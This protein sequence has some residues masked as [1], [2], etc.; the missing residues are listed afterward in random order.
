MLSLK[1]G[2][3]F[4]IFQCLLFTPQ[5]DGDSVWHNG[6]RELD[7]ILIVCRREEQHL[8]VLLQ[9]SAT[10]HEDT[11]T[12]EVRCGWL[13][14]LMLSKLSSSRLS[15]ITT[16]LL[17]MACANFITGASYVAEN[18]SIWQ[19][20]LS[21]LLSGIAC[22]IVCNNTDFCAIARLGRKTR[23]GVETNK[24]LSRRA[25]TLVRSHLCIRMDWSW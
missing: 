1:Q 15:R 9:A 12:R 24:E 7:D 6:L 25:R 21:K 2:N 20:F 3:L 10:Q 17:M 14:C 8:T 19:A 23:R 18:S 16:G 4:N 22:K 13:T 11:I 5:S